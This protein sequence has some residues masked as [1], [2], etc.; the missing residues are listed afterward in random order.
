MELPKGQMLVTEVPYIFMAEY[1]DD[2]NTIGRKASILLKEKYEGTPAYLNTINQAQE[3]SLQGS[4]YFYKCAL[5]NIYSELLGQRITPATITEGE[6]ALFHNK[7]GEDPGTF[8]EDFGF[9]VFPEQGPN[10]EYHQSI[11]GQV[12]VNFGNVDLK[13]PFVITGSCNPVKDDKYANGLRLDLNELTDVY[14][15][16]TLKESG[17]YGFSSRDPGLQRTGFPDRFEENGDRELYVGDSGVRRL[18]RGRGSYLDAWDGYLAGSVGA[19]RVHLVANFSSG[20]LD[21][22]VQQ[23][24]Q[25]KLKQQQELETRYNQALEILKKR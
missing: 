7:L 9:T 3:G 12:K 23:L 21:E 14:N 8:Y 16:L 22:L 1:N 18:C 13:L 5:A 24:E 17:L 20:N 4:N 6:I 25:E 10:E 19:G 15:V 2:G 11:R